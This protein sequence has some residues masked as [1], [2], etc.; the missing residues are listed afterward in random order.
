MTMAYH[1]LTTALAFTA[2][3]VALAALLISVTSAIT[4]IVWHRGDHKPGATP[5]ARADRATPWPN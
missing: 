4:F 1:D 2:L 3:G 5:T